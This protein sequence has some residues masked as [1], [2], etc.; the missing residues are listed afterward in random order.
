MSRIHPVSSGG[1]T[2]H[3]MWIHEKD[4]V[5]VV[6]FALSQANSAW[7]VLLSQGCSAVRLGEESSKEREVAIT[8]W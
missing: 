6:A 3:L 2:I 4:P 7:Q 8:E 1:S 5:R